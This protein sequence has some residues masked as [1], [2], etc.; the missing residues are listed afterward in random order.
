M[1]GVTNGLNR[2]E[3]GANPGQSSAVQAVVDEFGPS[4][5]SEIASDYDIAT[6]EAN[7]AAA[8]WLAQFVFGPNTTLS[9]RENPTSMAAA[10]PV[11]YV[12]ASSPPFLL[13]HG[14]ADQ[15]VS[16]SQTLILHNALRARGVESTRYVI[17]GANHG[18]L[19]F[20]GFDPD[21]AKP[22]S[23]E[24]VMHGIVSFLSKHLG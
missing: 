3:D 14:I 7:Y 20:L 6:Q 4:D 15:L 11:S 21:V 18:D 13:L 12:T 1:T 8:N 19:T 22:W 23:A 9:V 17:M 10:N 16:P 5:I 24:H 2:F